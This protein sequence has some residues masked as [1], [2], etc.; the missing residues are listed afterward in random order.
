[1]STLFPPSRIRVFATEISP[2]IRNAVGQ[3]IGNVATTFASSEVLNP[4][5]NPASIV[6]PLPGIALCRGGGGDAHYDVNQLL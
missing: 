3:V 1:M 6:K 2:N 5:S 4:T